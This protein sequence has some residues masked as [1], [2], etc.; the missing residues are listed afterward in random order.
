MIKIFSPDKTFL[1]TEYAPSLTKAAN[2][3]FIPVRSYD[4]L[5]LKYHEVINN[6]MLTEVYFINPSA[7]LLSELF[8]SMF[9]IID[10]AGGLV[11]NDKGQ[12]LFIYRNGKWD[13]PKGKIEKG[14][15]IKVAATREVEE[16][17]GISKLKIVKELPPT[18]H[19]YSLEDKT[20]LK[21]TYWFEMTCADTS[22]LVPQTEEG[23]TDVKWFNM[24]EVRQALKNTYGSIKEVVKNGIA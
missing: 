19:I 6:K 18:Y 9:T 4:E 23:I 14:E 5:S 17:C 12:W 3:V 16:E 2:V 13:L 21:R 1:M 10:A 22:L 11:R 24:E 7:K 20:V 8:L 15:K